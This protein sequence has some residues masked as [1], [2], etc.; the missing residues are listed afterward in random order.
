MLVVDDT[1]CTIPTVGILWGRSF[2]SCWNLMAVK[3]LTVPWQFWGSGSRVES[4]WCHYVMIE[5]DNQLNHC[6]PHPYWTHKT[7]LSTLKCCFWACGSSLKQLYPHYL[8]QILGF[9][10][11]CGVKMMSLYHGWGWHPPQT[12]S[13]IH[14]LHIQSVWAHWYA[15]HGHMA[16]ASNKYTHIP[17][18]RIWGS[19]GN[20]WSQ[21]DGIMSLLRLTATSN[22]ILHPY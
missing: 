10:V 6:F 20:L 17:W 22:C 4:K 5:P 16:V 13:Y 15:V 14:V 12:T 9:W 18:V 3:L 21:N 1:F 11:T 2:C 19:M 7:C 8:G